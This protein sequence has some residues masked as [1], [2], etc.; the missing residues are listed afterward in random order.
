MIVLGEY[1]VS[2]Q[3][4]KV[5][6]LHMTLPVSDKRY[7]IFAPSSHSLPVIRCMATDASDA[8]ISLH[9]C[10]S[11]LKALELL[12]P[13][14]ARMWNN[15]S[16]T[17]GSEYEH[18]LSNKKRSSFQLVRRVLQYLVSDLTYI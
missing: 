14:Y 5:A 16:R 9:Q 10:D 12:S 7:R 2:V 18:L 13:L 3:K 1:E 6:I 15:G 4:G 11:G 8:E 17:F